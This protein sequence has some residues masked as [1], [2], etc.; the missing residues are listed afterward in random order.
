MRFIASKQVFA[1]FILAVSLLTI[2]RSQN[3]QQE[4]EILSV[5]STDSNL[6]AEKV[7]SGPIPGLISDFRVLDV[8]SIYYEAKNHS[9]YNNLRPIAN[10]LQR[11]Q[12]LDPKFYDVYRLSSSFLAY[13]AGQ[14]KVAISLLEKGIYER[15][16]IW[17][18]PFYA[19]FIAHDLLKND[20]LAFELMSRVVTREGT[21]QIIIDLATR[22][23][24]SSS[25]KEDAIIFLQGLQQL[26]PESYRDGIYKRIQELES[27]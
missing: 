9:Q 27:E 10:Y 22:F 2:V 19:G 15:P 13:D 23:L 16:E 6:A 4:V 24:A 3:N 11:A 7:L 26:L 5:W 8:F 25:T 21:P 1:C 14:P 12:N 18:I 17:E 20:K